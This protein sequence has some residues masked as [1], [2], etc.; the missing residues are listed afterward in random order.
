MLARTFSRILISAI[1][2]LFV[3][4]ALSALFLNQIRYDWLVDQVLHGIHRYDLFDVVTQK[5]FTIEKFKFLKNVSWMLSAVSL[6]I[7]Y[8]MYVY[9]NFLIIKIEGWVQGGLR[10]NSAFWRSVMH[11]SKN[12]N[13]FLGISI[14]LIAIRSIYYASTF[15]IQYDEAWNYNFFLHNNIFYT[16]VAYN[17]YPLHNLISWIF[18]HLLSANTFVLR[19]PSILAGIITCLLVFV[20]IKKIFLN[21]WLAL[22]CSLLFAC[23]PISV[24]YMLYARGVMFEIFFSLV[25]CYFLFTRGPGKLTMRQIIFLSLLN[26]FATYSMLSHV[27]FIG[28]SALFLIIFKIIEGPWQIKYLIL[29]PVLSIGFSLV[30]LLPMALG[31]GLSSGLQSSV[32]NASYLVLHMMPYHCYSDFM[33]GGWFIFYILIVA[34]VILLF[35]KTSTN[36]RILILANLVLLASPLIIRM[37]TGIFPPERGLA[38]LCII[39]ITTVAMLFDVFKVERSYLMGGVVCA[40]FVLSYITFHHTKLNWSKEL[41][42]QVY[43]LASLLMSKADVSIYST[44]SKFNYFVPGV[45]YYYSSSGRNFKYS[46]ND[47]GSSRYRLNEDAP[48]IITESYLGSDNLVFSY[49]SMYVYYKQ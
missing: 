35:I 40:I 3:A 29:Y 15:Y 49:D 2:L 41:D 7:L 33:T 46:T 12:V 1:V 11:N 8:A 17:N 32:G 18:V 38:F 6:A 20:A 28:F 36:K 47:T 4:L 37:G 5:Y 16:C 9:R 44:S 26:A 10:L 24:F 21:E 19:L 34:N 31:T 23:L 39:P 30:L 45:Q 43:K 25:I 14:G 22:S 42:R 27:Y 48:C 13:V